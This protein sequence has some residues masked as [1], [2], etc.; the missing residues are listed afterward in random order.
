VLHTVTLGE[1]PASI[2]ERYGVRGDALILANGHKPRAPLAGGALTWIE[3]YEGE[4]LR[5]PVGQLG[6]AP[7]LAG[8]LGAATAKVWS[9]VFP[10]SS[11]A[12]AFQPG[13]RYAA[14]VSA[15]R[16]FT[17]AA[18]VQ[19]VA[20][21]GATVTY[22][23]EQG[24]PTRGQYPID[25]WLANLAADATSNHRWIYLEANVT[26]AQ[27]LTFG[28][29][30]P[31]P[32]TVYHVAHVLEAVDAPPGQGGGGQVLPT[33]PGC[34]SMPSPWPSRLLGAAVGAALTL[35]VVAIR[36]R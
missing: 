30:A 35:G 29:D 7:P 18:I 12:F 21:Y 10:D 31:W 20:S 26:A 27:P 13:Q 1:T 32:L 5:V 9:E 3:L 16:N 2:A 24:T 34:P 14:L 28:Q 4:R 23:W 17:L 25:A 15:S 8:Q 36:A 22:A 19:K 6:A 11:G 33:G